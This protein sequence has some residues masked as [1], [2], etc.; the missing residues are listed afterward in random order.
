MVAIRITADTFISGEPVSKGDEL[1]V[2]EG[3]ARELLRWKK[4]VIL[5]PADAAAEAQKPKL[6][7]FTRREGAKPKAAKAEK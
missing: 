1:N 4:C 5:E 6:P 7:K 3:V 2:D